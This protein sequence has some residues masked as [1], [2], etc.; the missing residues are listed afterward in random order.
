MQEMFLFSI[1]FLPST[2]VVQDLHIRLFL[3]IH[4]AAKKAATIKETLRLKNLED[5]L[6]VSLFRGL[7]NFIYASL[8]VKLHTS[9]VDALSLEPGS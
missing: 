7:D 5:N 1:S 2:S 9:S 3:Q 8:R 6:H 4:I